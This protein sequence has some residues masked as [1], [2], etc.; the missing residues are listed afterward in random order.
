MPDCPAEFFKN[1]IGERERDWLI[2]LQGLTLCNHKISR[3]NVQRNDGMCFSPVHTCMHTYR[4]SLGQPSYH[5]ENS[6]QMT[7]QYFISM[8]FFVWGVVGGG[9]CTSLFVL[10][11]HRKVPILS[12]TPFYLLLKPP[13]DTLIISATIW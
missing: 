13:T 4:S 8:V 10:I 12:F 1:C 2:C 9:I 6:V 11:L 7:L 3:I 5:R